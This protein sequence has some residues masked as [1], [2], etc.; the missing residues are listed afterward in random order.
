MKRILPIVLVLLGAVS[1]KKD[2]FQ[3]ID[4]QY[5][6]E[7]TA[8][9]TFTFDELIETIAKNWSE[10]GKVN[11]EEFLERY[12]SDI[13]QLRPVYRTQTAYSIKY[14]TVDPFGKE[15]IASGVIYHPATTHLKG[16]VEISSRNVW[17]EG[18]ASRQPLAVELLPA[19][20]GY[21]MMIPDLIGMGAT[22]DLPFEAGIYDN[23]ARVSADLREA[24]REFIHNRYRQDVPRGSHI[25]GYS[26][27]G[28]NA[29][30]LARFYDTHRE[31]QVNVMDVYTGGG[32]YNLK[33][34]LDEL[35]AAG[36]S[37]YPFLAIVLHSM[38]YYKGLG[39]APEKLFRGKL[40]ENYEELCSGSKNVVEL[41]QLL[42]TRLEDYLNLDELRPG[43]ATYDRLMEAA[44][45]LRISPEW[46]PSAPVYLFHAE[47]DKYVPPTSAEDLA[48][49]WKQAGAPVTYTA[50][51]TDDH[52]NT[53]FVVAKALL[54]KLL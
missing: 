31:R 7:V 28:G 29:L 44:E 15:I 37:N 20:N 13:E 52:L 39:I 5:F 9:R 33:T 2:T 12:Q 14:K 48:A 25:F 38:N 46:I 19:L 43:Q 22:N 41:T 53:F 40:L 34:T 42:G 4:C 30:A 16:V 50:V 3:P 23:I 26:M 54:E 47:R 32:T 51:D 21:L 1:C 18:C 45:A 10:N 27:A 8:E 35:L 17:K 6:V 11:A 49:A 36:E 24:A